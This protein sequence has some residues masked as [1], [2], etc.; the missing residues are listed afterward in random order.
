MYSRAATP[1]RRSTARA[2]ASGRRG[3]SHQPDAKV[4]RRAHR[5]S[6]AGEFAGSRSPRTDVRLRAEV[7]MSESYYKIIDGKKFDKQMLE[8]A[9]AAASGQGDGRISLADARR[10][11]AA[12]TDGGRYTDVEKDTMAHIRENFKFT[13]EADTWFRDEIRRFAAR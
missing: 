7:I 11:I 4:R 13:E 1:S 9:E 8:V 2:T 6:G 3:S 12:V 5:G 10:L